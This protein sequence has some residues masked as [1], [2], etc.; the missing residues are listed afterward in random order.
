[1]NENREII[2]DSTTYVYIVMAGELHEGGEVQG[3][4]SSLDKA[5]QVVVD[6]KKSC[7]GGNDPES[8]TKPSRRQDY[9]TAGCDWID[10]LT[11]RVD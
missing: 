10:I 1:M 6:L 5:R 9:H 8:W 11:C 4:Y 3:V 7:Y 2:V